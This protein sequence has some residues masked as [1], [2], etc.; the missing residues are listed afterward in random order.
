MGWAI[1][2]SHRSGRDV[3]VAHHVFPTEVGETWWLPIRLAGDER[4]EAGRHHVLPTEVS[5]AWWR[6]ISLTEVSGTG[7]AGG[8]EPLSPDSV[9]AP[10][11]LSLGLL[12]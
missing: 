9:H 2:S 6:P 12:R 5:R 7:S 1:T 10:S 4:G 8:P 3:V 11:L